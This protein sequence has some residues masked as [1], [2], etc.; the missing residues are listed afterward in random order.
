MTI[1]YFIE[2][3]T[4]RGCGLRHYRAVCWLSYG[5]GLTVRFA[6]TKALKFCGAKQFKTA[7]AAE[8]TQA[9]FP[10]ML[11]G[12]RV[13][14]Y[15]KPAITNTDRYDLT[16]KPFIM[17]I[18]T[19]SL[20]PEVSDILARQVII[21]GH[22]VKMPPLERKLYERVN[23]ALELLGGKWL[24]S[25]KAHVFAD[26]PTGVITRALMD[27]NVVD[28]KKTYQFFPTPP[29]LARRMA[30]LLGVVPTD[31]VLEPSAGQG[32]LLDAL[33]ALGVDA[34][35]LCCCELNPNHQAVLRRKGYTKILADDF[36]TLND[37]GGR[38]LFDKIIANPPFTGN[39]DID[40]VRKMYDLLKP[41]GRLVVLMSPS[42]QT[43]SQRK[44]AEFRA[45]VEENSFPVS[46]I[47]AGT[48]SDTNI[49]TVLLTIGKPGT[50]PMINL[51]KECPAAVQPTK[52]KT[53]S[54]LQLN[55]L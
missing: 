47:P 22:Q 53:V 5:F 34:T 17:K 20:D 6:G 33:V 48:F 51:V 31:Q 52:S 7:A 38:R 35:Q 11:R 16:P 39:Q 42:W 15:E 8:T 37:M 24:R 30:V 49:R 3:P 29:D 40:H 18:K 46:E 25:A 54:R 2:L 14:A 41:G 23:K 55:L 12:S 36:L 32:A 28:E 27:G 9:R 19:V 44:Q 10:N 50:K 4:P 43:G 21:T 13:V 26:D 1:S 45:W